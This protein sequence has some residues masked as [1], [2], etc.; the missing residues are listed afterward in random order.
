MVTLVV[1]GT[2]PVFF[3]P[4]IISA[5]TISGLMV[6]GL[7]PVFLFWRKPVPA[8]S[9]HAA[10]GAGLAIGIGTLVWGTPAWMNWGDTTYSATLGASVVGTGLAFI[11]FLGSSLLTPH[12]RA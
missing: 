9:F 3:S 2:V 4:E 7:A 1:L 11:L 12:D 10:V 5:T 6:V 8:W